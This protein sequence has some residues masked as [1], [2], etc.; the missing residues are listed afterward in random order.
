M[1][2]ILYESYDYDDEFEAV[3]YDAANDAGLL[4]AGDLKYYSQGSYCDYNWHHTANENGNE[5]V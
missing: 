3:A 5:W 4:E 1:P 2:F